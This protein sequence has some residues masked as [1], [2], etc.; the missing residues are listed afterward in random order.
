MNRDIHS[1]KRQRELFGFDQSDIDRDERRAALKK[2]IGM[3]VLVILFFLVA[4][5]A[6]KADVESREMITGIPAAVNR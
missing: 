5:L 1:L 4:G 6:G 3:F 2:K